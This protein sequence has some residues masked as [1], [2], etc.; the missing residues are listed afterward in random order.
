MAG[1]VGAARAVASPKGAWA[2]ALGTTAT[3][4][5]SWVSTS[6]DIKLLESRGE[7]FAFLINVM[8][9]RKNDLQRLFIIVKK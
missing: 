6:S 7:T 3:W 2:E 5:W 9:S 1:S 8:F 4:T